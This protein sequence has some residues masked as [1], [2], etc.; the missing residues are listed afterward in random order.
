VRGHGQD[1]AASFRD[2]I[3]AGLFET[4]IAVIIMSFC[5]GCAGI[6]AAPAAQP[7]TTGISLTLSPVNASVLLGKTTTVSAAVTN[8]TNV[9]VNWSVNDIPAGNAT[10][11]TIVANAGGSAAATFTAP[12]V[13]PA[14]A[15]VN[16]EAASVADPTKIASATIDIA[17]DVG[18]SVSPASSAVELGA[19]QTLQSSITSAGNPST[20]V[21]WKA[22]GAGC[23]GAACGTVNSA[24]FFTAPQILPSPP[25]VTVTATS[26]ADPAKS[27]AASMNMTSH[28]TLA[29][30]AAGSV[31]AGINAGTSVNLSA[32]ISP[33]SGSNPSTEIL[34]SLSGTGCSGA[35]CGTLASAGLNTGS[36]ST[37]ATYTA[38]AIAPSP[39][40][41]T[42][43]ATSVAD[44]SKTAAISVSIN[45][46]VSITISPT[47]ATIAPG[48]TTNFAGM[49]NGTTNTGVTWDVNGI[50]GGNSIVGSI[51]GAPGNTGQAIYT[52]PVTIPTTNPVAIRARSVADPSETATASVTIGSPPVSIQVSP[53]SAALSI[54]HRETFQAAVQNSANTVVIWQVND[55][56]GGNATVG[57]ICIAGS[58]P[59]QPATSGVNGSVDYLAPQAV[60]SP[61]PV[62]ITAISQA[63]VTKMAGSAVTILP[64]DVV[65]VSPPSITLA[66]GTSQLFS[67]FIAGTVNQQVT[68]NVAGAGC[69]GAGAPCGTID[70]TGLY[71]TPG[72]AP[73]PNTLSIVATSADD[74]SRAASAAVTITNQP[75]ILSL[76][77]SSAIA[78]A[79]GFSLQVAGANFAASSP[80]PGSVVVIGGTIRSTVCQSAMACSV[81]L[82]AADLAVAE[83]LSVVVQDPG[84]SSSSAVF[85]VVEQAIQ[86]AGDITLTPASPAATGKDIVVVDLS[87]NG[88]TS[89]PAEANLG[90]SA[91]GIYQAATGTC[92]L[93]SGPVE[94]TRPALG[95]ATANICAFS[96]SGLDP[97]YAYTLSGPLPSDAA[98]VATSSLGFG[99]VQLT[100]ALPS[101]AATG[102]RTLFIQNSNLD[103]ASAS[104]AVDIE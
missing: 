49:V 40:Q 51:T 75:A 3:V 1:C 67:A 22:T 77:P 46:V 41:V 78:G 104:G 36:L 14:S 9:G 23:S 103:L 69:G 37:A 83:N 95:T 10:V 90:V 32:T 92:S 39:A 30:S 63:D 24:G 98:I 64:H 45:P 82:S 52:A 89:P 25:A 91:I 42:I 17:S 97:L 59:C 76:L 61:N 96:A 44:P 94:L 72:G 35:A 60:P 100:I 88:S 65:S 18:I 28:F 85:F 48:S 73:V 58:N 31:T 101:T 102:P 6:A 99:I 34:W 68:W 11:G 74:T 55:I 12:Q 13:M 80:G 29:I 19:L 21:I 53:A 70:A 16:I 26:V 5:S 81:T 38:P 33:V 84:G 50:T 47:A 2:A 8:T 56:A 15:T 62:T 86:S 87:G 79:A 27:A 66:P 20:A 93:N 57:Q 54:N 4:M 43:I 71:V 7:P